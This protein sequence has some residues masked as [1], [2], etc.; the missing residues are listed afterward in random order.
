MLVYIA[1]EN[2]GGCPGRAN[3]EVAVDDGM[4][5]FMGQDPL[6]NISG[7]KINYAFHTGTRP[8]CEAFSPLCGRISGSVPL[9][10]DTRVSGLY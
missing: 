2:L 10:S 5:E 3:G 8:A 9:Y 6:M 1:R 7:I 4:S